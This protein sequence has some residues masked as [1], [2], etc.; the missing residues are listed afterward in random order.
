[1]SSSY[2]ANG[3]RRPL[4][5]TEAEERVLD[6]ISREAE[7]RMRM[8][9]ETREQARQNRYAYLEKKV[10]EDAEV[11]RQDAASTSNGYGSPSCAEKKE[12]HVRKK[13]MELQ[14]RVQQAMFF[15]IHSSTMKK[16][17]L[18]YEVDLLKDE[19]EEKE[20]SLNLTNKECRNLTTE[21]KALRRTV[22]A[23]HH[24]Q[25]QLKAEIAHRDQLIQDNGLVLV[26][27]EAEGSEESS[28][29]NAASTQI[30]TGPLLFSLETIRL[31][32]RVV[33]GTATLDQKIQKLVD[34]NKKMRKDYEEMEQTIYS[35]RVARN[36]REAASS[37]S[38][39]AG[40]DDV[41]KDAVKQLAEIKLKMQ[42][43]ERENTNHQG[44]VIRMEGQMKRFKTNADTAEKELTELKTQMRQ[45]KKELRDKENLLDEAK[46]TNKHLQSRMEK[47]RNQRTGR[48]V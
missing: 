30:P 45:L 26:E 28:A 1:M 22:E 13:V 47:M 42:D 34:M 29:T 8:K 4:T 35:Q 36:N 48:P 37:V 14:D 31:V 33:P 24:T 21:V 15:C 16:S 10:E 38:N 6:K 7:A 20:A 9:R 46:E 44:N 19:L 39:G 18:L 32:E 23:L 2:S 25:N 27:Q 5:R 17:S 41:N 43:L 40:V 12:L 11:Y 3:R